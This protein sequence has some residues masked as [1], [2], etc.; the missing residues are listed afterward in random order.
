MSNNNEIIEHFKRVIEKTV[1]T[2]DKILANSFSYEITKRSDS[3]YPFWKDV[4]L[5]IKW[6]ERT[7][8]EEE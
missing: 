6:T 4:E 3:K 2:N 7:E 5:T 1:P 8:G